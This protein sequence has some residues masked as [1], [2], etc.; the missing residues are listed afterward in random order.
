MYLS[1]VVLWE[2][3]SYL[4][5]GGFK[6]V[7]KTFHMMAVYSLYICIVMHF[8]FSLMIWIADNLKLIKNACLYVQIIQWGYVDK[9]ST[10]NQ[11]VIEKL[12][13]I[14]NNIPKFISVIPTHRDRLAERTRWSFSWI[15]SAFSVFI[16]GDSLSYFELRELIVFFICVLLRDYL[17]K[18]CK[19][20]HDNIY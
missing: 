5:D 6:K 10:A 17:D 19:G 7:T 18:N 13:F 9:F 3:V 16:N 11:K 14:Y 4:E 15:W 2:H 1:V 12:L 20:E 8:T